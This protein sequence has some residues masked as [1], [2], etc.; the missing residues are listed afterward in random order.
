MEKF[1]ELL[2]D[3]TLSSRFHNYQDIIDE[4]RKKR[5]TC[6]YFD[7]ERCKKFIVKDKKIPTSWITDDEMSPHPL[8]CY[9]C[10]KYSIK[11]EEEE[12]EVIDLFDFLL[13]YEKFKEEVEREL[14]YLDQKRIEFPFQ[15]SLKRRREDLIILL[16][17]II[18]K[19]KVLKELIK[20]EAK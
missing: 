5:D 15:L 14:I 16:D 13:Y 19:I 10:P 17:D 18:N 11:K 7:G 6:A 8:I 20:F 9:I 3:I 2:I 1:R 12:K 4:G